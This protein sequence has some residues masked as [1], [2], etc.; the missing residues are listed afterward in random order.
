MRNSQSL[1]TRKLAEGNLSES[2]ERKS[3]VALEI[4]I[5]RK[6]ALVYEK[7]QASI[8]FPLV[9]P[10][11]IGRLFSEQ[12][13]GATLDLSV[14]GAEN[15]GV[16]RTH[17]RL[18]PENEGVFIED[19]GSLNGTRVNGVVLPAHTPQRIYHADQIRLGGL[20]LKIEFVLDPLN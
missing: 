5:P 19:L 6:L 2:V 15:L 18:W 10:V 13:F 9:K 14:F 4:G 20:D 3:A 8:I 11:I 7:M 1:K 17:I 12:E 16:S